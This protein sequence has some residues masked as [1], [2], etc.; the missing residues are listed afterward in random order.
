MMTR[1]VVLDSLCGTVSSKA[2]LF[3]YPKIYG[4]RISPSDY[5][6]GCF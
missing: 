6:S 1:L 3:N 4:S 5:G 2:I